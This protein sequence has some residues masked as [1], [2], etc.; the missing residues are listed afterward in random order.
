MNL[1][2][3][4]NKNFTTQFNKMS[5]KY[6]EEFEKINGFSEDNF[7]LS[8]FIDHFIDSQNNA[9]A[10]IDA[11]A[12]VQGKDISNLINEIPKPYLKLL[13][14]NKLFYELQKK[15][16]YKRATQWLEASWKGDIFDHNSSDISFRPYC[17]NYDLTDLA[18]KGMYF[19]ENIKTGPAKHLTTFADH[20]LETVSWVSNRTSGGCGLAN[21][22]MWFFWFWKNDVDNNYYT[23]DPIYYRDQI[24]QKFIFDCNMPYLRITQCAYT[25]IS[26]FDRI[27]CEEMFGGFIYPDGKM[28]IDYIDEFIEFEK[29]FMNKMEEMREENI[30]TFPVITYS[31]VYRDN[32]FQDEEFAHWCSDRNIK[33][34]DA[35]FLV[36]SSTSSTAACCRLLNDTSKV[37][38]FVNSIGGGDVGIGSLCVETLNLA[39]LAYQSKTKEEFFEKLNETTRL[40]IDVNDTIRHIITRNIEKGLLPN[41]SLGLINI[42]AQMC[43]IGCNGIAEAVKYFD[44]IQYDDFGCAS[45]TDEGLQFAIDILDKINEIKDS[46]HFDYAINV[47]QCPMENGAVKL[48]AKNKLLY[49]S[50]EY[51]TGN[52]WM[53]LKEKATIKER[54]RLAGALDSK[55]GGGCILHC[56]LE[57]PFTSSEQAWKVLNY[58]AAQGVVYFAFNLKIGVDNSG[59]TFTSK[60]C[61]ICGDSPIETY[62]RVVG[63]MTRTKSWSEMRQREYQERDWMKLDADLILN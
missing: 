32:K 14:Y 35:N 15:Y 57:S 53:P 1:S 58:M 34:G 36:S 13:S 25:T 30:Y 39:G 11:N 40:I 61:P 28:F 8:H 29:A 41:Y 23:K 4:L 5:E 42:K 46:Y 54:C 22:L 9:D 18:K 31:L 43:T 63:Y 7:N 10:T 21:V 12:N 55:V 44:G 33:Y 37:Q 20:V 60:K 38:G 51:I 62:S 45:Y 19:I 47:E 3:I 52:Q 48:A 16:G 6:G 2:L 17:W 56:Q 49:N 59:H 26:I 50:E 27:Y 24:F